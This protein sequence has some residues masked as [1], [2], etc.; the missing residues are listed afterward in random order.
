MD[1]PTATDIRSDYLFGIPLTDDNGNTY[2]S[3]NINR[4][5]NEAIAWLEDELQIKINPTIITDEHHDYHI[6]EYQDFCY[7][8]LYEFP[9]VSV[10]S[11]V[12]AYAGQDIMTFPQDWIHIYNKTGQLQ[13]VPTTGSLSQVLIGQGSGML[14]P[15]ITRRLSKMPHLFRV[16]YTAGFAEGAV[17]GNISDLIAKKTCISILNVMGDILLGAGIASQS[18]SIDGL[19]ENVN[20]TQSAENSAYSARIRQYEKEIKIDL[21][22]L[23]QKYKGLRFGVA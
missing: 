12:A 20:T 8:Q 14:L 13:L 2:S 19:S 11:L 22:T 21:P 18:I 7:I 16:A 4:R 23:K 15:L 6:N 17:P 5:I 1:I 10:Q 3:T 9:V